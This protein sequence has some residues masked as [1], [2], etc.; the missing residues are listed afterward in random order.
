MQDIAEGLYQEELGD[1]QG[2]GSASLQLVQR[3][4]RQIPD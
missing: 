2:S 4:F 1:L 3:Y